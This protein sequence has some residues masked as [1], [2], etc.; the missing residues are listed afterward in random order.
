MVYSYAIDDCIVPLD[1]P[2]PNPSAPT[3]PSWAAIERQS[4][5]LTQV[6]AQIRQ[7]MLPLYRH[8]VQPMLTESQLFPYISATFPKG[9]S[10]AIGTL[11]V[12]FPQ[13]MAYKDRVDLKPLM[14]LVRS[15]RNLKLEF[16]VS[17]VPP[18]HYGDTRERYTKNNFLDP[19]FDVQAN[20]EGLKRAAYSCKRITFQS[21]QLFTTRFDLHWAQPW[22]RQGLYANE[23][24][25]GQSE[26]QDEGVVWLRNIGIDLANVD[27]WTD[28]TVVEIYARKGGIRDFH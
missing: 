21:G 3:T 8:R 24:Y 9:S 18:Q 15:A 6:C 25:Q 23:P 12:C 14:R 27:D 1:K 17:P 19:F 4:L 26:L 10:T 11:I 5:G 16:R 7:E 2:R 22:F 28:N 13:K 20:K